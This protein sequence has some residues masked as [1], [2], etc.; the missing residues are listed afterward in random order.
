MS[1]EEN[2]R[3]VQRYV[4]EVANRHDLAVVEELIAATYTSW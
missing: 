2:K 3:I 4:A 1:T